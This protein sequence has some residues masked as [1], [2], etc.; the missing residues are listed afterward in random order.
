MEELP[1]TIVGTGE[2]VTDFGRP[3]AGVDANQ[4]HLETRSKVVGKSLARHEGSHYI[5]WETGAVRGS[6]HEPHYEH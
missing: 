4:D 1:E 6:R 3:K 2:V 5:P